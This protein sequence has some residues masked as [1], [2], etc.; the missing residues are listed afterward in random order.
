[1]PQSAM[2][3]L[4]GVPEQ[5]PIVF[6]SFSICGPG[7]GS[8]LPFCSVQDFS[9][10]NVQ[11]R[12]ETG[13]GHLNATR[14][15]PACTLSWVTHFS[16]FLGTLLLPFC[17]CTRP[18]TP[19]TLVEALLSVTLPLRSGRVIDCDVAQLLGSA[20]VGPGRTRD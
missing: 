5:G 19:K 6:T 18:Y 1:M 15:K 14:R 16:H 13:A 7:K 9:G 4:S 2:L 12:S 8:I 17:L 11:E 20:V 3:L 10:D